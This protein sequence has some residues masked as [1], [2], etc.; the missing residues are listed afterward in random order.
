MLVHSPVLTTMASTSSSASSSFHTYMPFSFLLILFGL[1]Q[2][3][4]AQT[5]L[6]HTYMPFSFML[7]L[8]AVA[9]GTM[10]M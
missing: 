1:W 10:C 3:L 7:I 9:F 8:L 5:W 2:S 6:F 4:H